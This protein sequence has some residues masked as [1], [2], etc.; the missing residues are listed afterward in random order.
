MNICT[1]TTY[2]SIVQCS[3]YCTG[4]H[5]LIPLFIH[6]FILFWYILK[7]N[8]R[9]SVYVHMNSSACISLSNVQHMFMFFI[10]KFTCNE[11]YISDVLI[12]S[13]EKCIHLSDPKSHED[14]D[15]IQKIS[16]VFL[17]CWFPHNLPTRT[18]HFFV[19]FIQY[20][21]DLVF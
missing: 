20:R 14:I 5:L 12:L 6:Q 18:K 2:Y 15:I 16:L 21:P 19:L 8:F 17:Q 9:Q 13:F 10:V 7:I 3:F 11:M 1:P 4:V